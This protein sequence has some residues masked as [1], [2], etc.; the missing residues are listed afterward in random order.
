MRNAEIASHFEELGDLY[1]LDGAIVH[2]VVAYRNAA[3]AIRDASRSVAEL[4]RAGRATEL[5]GVGKTIA[6]K[7]DTLLE[8]G[9][10]PQSEKLKERF[11]PGLVEIT[12]IPGFG[13]KRARRVFDEL[14]IASI[15]ELR[16]A[17]EAQQLRGVPGFGVKAEESVLATLAANPDGSP[18]ARV[19]LSRARAVGEGIVA[20][21]REHPACERAELA[22][23]V[24]RMAETCKDL[25]VVVASRDPA[26]LV[27]AF[28]GLS[29]LEVFSTSDSGA[30]AET[31]NGLPVDLRVV[32]PE[33]FGNLLQHFT[34]SGAHNEALRTQSVRRGMHV[35]E[36][37]VIDDE[38]GVTHACATEEEVYDLLGLT[39]VPPELRENRGELEAAREGGLP[40]LVRID[41]L[42]GDL[43]CHTIASDGRSTVE[44]MAAAARERGYEFLAITDHSAT[45]GFGKDVSPDALRRHVEHIRAV[46]ASFGDDF[47]VLA[48][49]EVNVLP[50]GALDYDDELLAELDWVIASLHSSFRMGEKE[51]TDR[52]IRAIEHPLVDAIGHPTGRLIERREPYAL[53]LDRVFEAAART[54]TFLEINGNPDRRDLSETNARRAVEAGVTLVLDSDAHGPEILPSI[55][56]AVATARRA[57][58][59]PDRIAN[60]RPWAEL[61]ALR[62]HR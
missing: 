55:G 6:E 62:R 1:E 60:A 32:A 26:A 19:L 24:R 2:R 22:G 14:G 17:A 7:I 56:Y 29:L 3:R 9:S 44:G 8:R 38:R 11:P 28:R 27:E 50:D 41:S 57:W 16:R 35:S 15:D 34:G 25:D 12:R 20:A 43:H 39:Y 58:V 59:G 37:G 33:N 23:S 49:S 51:M 52:M 61:D 54:G 31:H 53:D 46:D 47:R 42:H 18:R 10:L 30:R 48:G 40:D 13:S 4:A 21:L 5:S 45:H 36:Y